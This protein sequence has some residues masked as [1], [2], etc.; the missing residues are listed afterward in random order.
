MKRVGI[1]KSQARIKQFKKLNFINSLKP[2]DTNNLRAFSIYDPQ[3]L[4]GAIHHTINKHQK[5]NAMTAG[6][7]RYNET[8]NDSK[9]YLKPM[10]KNDLDHLQ[11]SE[12]QRNQ[13]NNTE[14]G[15]KF[16]E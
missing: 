16:F 10:I 9:K 1:S 14:F 4:K 8:R 6:I 2:S 15:H 3:H 12:I 7:D 11:K 13:M 5:R